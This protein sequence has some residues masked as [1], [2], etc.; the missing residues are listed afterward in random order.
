MKEERIIKS[1]NIQLVSY[2]SLTQHPKIITPSKSIPKI[3]TQNQALNSPIIHVFVRCFH[4]QLYEPFVKL[5][6]RELCM[7]YD[8]KREVNDIKKKKTNK[9]SKKRC[10]ISLNLLHQSRSARLS[11]PPPIR[12]PK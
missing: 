9:S 11:P 2:F 5:F 4:R 10:V 8:N 7:F 12:P 3:L 6:Y 1:K